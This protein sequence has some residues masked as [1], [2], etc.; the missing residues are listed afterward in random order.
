MKR[1]LIRTFLIGLSIAGLN[2]LVA[3]SQS[4]IQMPIADDANIVVHYTELLQP[5]S[6][7]GIYREVAETDRLYS[8]SQVLKSAFVEAGLPA[9]VDVVR[10][11]SRKNGDLD[12]TVTINRWDLNSMGEY[13]CRFTATVSNGT[14]K[15]NLG[16]FVGLLNELTL[17][18]G[19]NSEVTYDV[20]ARRAADKMVSHFIRA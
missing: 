15:I 13:E 16:V 17:H 6:M 7:G 2:P 10:N 1:S 11:G 20:A 18:R 14:E 3:G 9:R 5:M 4:P 12:I 8:F 19:T